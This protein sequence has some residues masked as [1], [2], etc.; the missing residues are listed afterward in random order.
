[1]DHLHRSAA[2]V[3][4]TSFDDDIAEADLYELA[5]ASATG[6]PDPSRAEAYLESHQVCFGGGRVRGANRTLSSR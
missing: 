4:L 6:G 2:S 3:K 1:M 5:D